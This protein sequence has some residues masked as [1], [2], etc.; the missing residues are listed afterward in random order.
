MGDRLTLQ[1]IA[2]MVIVIT[3]LFLSQINGRQNKT[4]EGLALTGKTA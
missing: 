1:N 2:G 3:G 4:D